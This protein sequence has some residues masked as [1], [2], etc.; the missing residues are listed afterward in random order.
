[1]ATTSPSH[2]PEPVRRWADTLTAS[3]PNIRLAVTQPRMPPTTWLAISVTPSRTA[4][5]RETTWTSVTT[6]LNEAET[7]CSARMS[8]VNAAPVAMLFSSS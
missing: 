8:A 5:S 3:S 1:M 6:G 4:T 7:P 2:W